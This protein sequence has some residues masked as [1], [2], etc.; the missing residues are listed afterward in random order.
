MLSKAEL[1]QAM[2]DRRH[3][4]GEIERARACGYICDQLESISLPEKVLVGG[5]LP[6]NQEVDISQWLIAT[7][8]RGNRVF[9]P[10][11]TKPEKTLKFLEWTAEAV[12]RT[13]AY[14][15][16]EPAG[17]QVGQPEVLLVPLVAF[18]RRGHRLGYGAGYYDATIAQLQ[19]LNPR[20]LT[21]GIAYQFQEVDILPAEAHDR[22][23]DMIV[24]DKEIIRI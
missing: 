21:I 6:I 18:D 5:Y 4:L 12:L 24:T 8:L 16:S 11:V 17:G 14:G 9:L 7:R 1:R 19:E 13:G 22:R 23:L 15:V 10:V 3:R 2:L 20:L